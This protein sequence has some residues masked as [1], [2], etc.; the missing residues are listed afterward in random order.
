[1]DVTRA[2][3]ESIVVRNENVHSMRTAIH[4]ITQLPSW[5]YQRYSQ[6]WAR[7]VLAAGWA[8]LYV[9]CDASV[10]AFPVQWRV[11]LAACIFIGGLFKP[12]IAYAAFIA[13]IAYPLYLI[14]IYLMALALAT[15]IL[16]APVVAFVPAG[17]EARLHRSSA[18]LSLA[19]LILMAPML[20]PFHLTPV[21][22]LL[23]GLW[24][25]R[26]ESAVGGGMVALWLKVCAAMSG[27]SPDL[28]RVDGWSMAI[29]PVY[30]RFHTANSLQ[31][32]IRLFGP[33][34]SDP[35]GISIGYSPD[36]PGIYLLFNLLQVFTWA[37]AGYTV[38]T[39]M[40]WLRVD[41]GR[42]WKAALSLGP[43]VL[44]IWAG[45]V[46]VPS[47]LQVEG[48]R[49]LD[50][51]WLPAQVV[52]AGFVV[53]GLDGLVR[54]LRQPVVAGRRPVRITESS[55]SPFS[56]HRYGHSAVRRSGRSQRRMEDNKGS[57]DPLE[58]L[59]RAK[60]KPRSRDEEDII[61]IE[62]D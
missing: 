62:L 27:H 29:D 41:K 51:L 7:A 56:P 2:R 3:R 11:V 17:M 36:P 6:I 18:G 14:S 58:L 19:L 48:P 57:R 39:L 26:T 38:S 52:L 35:T 5:L 4:S 23:I 31:T 46:A 21:L 30:G 40:H 32:L 42:G 13:A 12:V 60:R 54:Y 45:Y 28:W 22:P 61:M 33:L 8:F 43:G 44:L 47:W 10:E 25:G 20:A 1:M 50:P 15:L 16:S 49:W 37:A 59:K 53:W 55:P 24:W 9:L 34:A